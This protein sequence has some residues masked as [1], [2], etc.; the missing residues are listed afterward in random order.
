[1]PAIRRLDP[2]LVNKIAAGEVIERPASVVKELLENALDAG[3][4]R[5]D[6][7]LEDGGTT[8]IAVADDGRG[9]APDELPLALASHATSKIDSVDDLTAVSTMGF[10]G[11]ALA[12]IASVAR[13]RITSRPADRP[14]AARIDASDGRIGE[15]EPCAAPPGTMIEVR[16]LFFNMPARRKYLRTVAAETS[17][18]SEQIARIA[19]AHPHVAFSQTHQGRTMRRLPATDDR[20]VR[21][22]DFFG[23]DLAQ[24]LIPFD[25]QERELHVAGWFAPPAASRASS[26]WQYVFLN[27][28]YI[29]DR[30]LNGFVLREAFR[31]LIEPARYPVVFLFLTADPASFDVNVHPTKIEVR[32]RDAGRVKSQ[33]LAV[34]REALLSRDLTPALRAAPAPPS[35]EEAMR[36]AQAFAE[37]MR[38]TPPTIGLP[39]TPVFDSRAA[40]EWPRSGAFRDAWAEAHRPLP[41]VADEDAA[42]PDA[43]V[44]TDGGAAPRMSNEDDAGQ[45]LSVDGA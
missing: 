14:D 28:R 2:V 1:M 6:L 39:S 7:T 29:R 18:V 25:R 30:E 24:D 3:A 27:G 38:A 8:L 32:W 45:V 11:E 4:T 26:K 17:H 33:V 44:P 37:R 23:P 40:A 21:I 22:A 36:N 9:I 15:V 5:V 35:P 16:N 34:L 20:R 19:L 31:G 41:P 12:S 10:R 43:D 13:V 42:P